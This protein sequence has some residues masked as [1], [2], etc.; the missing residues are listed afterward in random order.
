MLILHLYFFTAAASASG[1]IGLL[2]RFFLF[3][4]ESIF[5]TAARKEA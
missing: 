2:D 4:A 1:K 5:E 3:M